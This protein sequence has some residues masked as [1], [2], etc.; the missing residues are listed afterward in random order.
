MLAGARSIVAALLCG[1]AA[2]SACSSGPERPAPGDDVVMDKSW[3]VIGI[4]TAP[5]A[6][7][8]I[9]DALPQAPS[10]TFGT[11]GFVGT[12]GCA[13]FRATASYQRAGEPA[14]VN[15]ADAVRIDSIAFDT[16]RADCTG[17][18]LWAHNQLSRLLHDDAQFDLNIDPA[19]QLILTLQDGQVDSPAIRFAS[20]NSVD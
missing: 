16:P 18:A 10:L 2:L 9:T 6:P 14:A 20:L 3:Q 19:N 17:A 1:T 5:Q 13:P 11:R 7:N 15:D 12:T 8:A 4:Y